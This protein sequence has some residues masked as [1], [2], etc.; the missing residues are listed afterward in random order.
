MGRRLDQPWVCECN[1]V[2]DWAPAIKRHKEACLQYL[3]ANGLTKGE[4]IPTSAEQPS[5]TVKPALP[6]LTG[7]AM[8]GRYLPGMRCGYLLDGVGKVGSAIPWRWRCDKKRS[9]NLRFPIRIDW[10]HC[11]VCHRTALPGVPG[12]A[13]DKKKVVTDKQRADAQNGGNKLPHKVEG[14]PTYKEPSPSEKKVLQVLSRGGELSKEDLY[15]R[16]PGPE[17]T[18]RKAVM[19]LRRREFIKIRVS[20]V[21]MSQTYFLTDKGRGYVESMVVT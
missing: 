15:E 14:G 19:Q 9:I 1:K 11:P 10:P 6:S 12:G 8:D 5:P 13:V 16:Y 18:L 2:M 20:I 7:S 3:K 21:D 17:L 4:K